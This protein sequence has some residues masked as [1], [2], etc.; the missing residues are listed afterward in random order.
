LGIGL[1]EE[2]RTTVPRGKNEWGEEDLETPQLYKVKFFCDNNIYNWDIEVLESRNG[3]YSNSKPLRA[4]IFGEREQVKALACGA[5]V[6]F[7]GIKY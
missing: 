1:L 6:Q 5:P 7:N 4:M 3:W 2:V